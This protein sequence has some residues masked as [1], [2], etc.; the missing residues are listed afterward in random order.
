MGR[1]I[2][3]TMKSVRTL[4]ALALAAWPVAAGAS[5]GRIEL[6]QACATTGGCVPGD[7]AG[8]PLSLSAGGSYV[9]TSNLTV[10]DANTSGIEITANDVTIDFNGFTLAGP[11]TVPIATHVCTLPGAGSGVVK[12]APASGS[13]LTL[14]NGHIRGMGAYGVAVDAALARID[15]MVIERNCASGLL[16]GLGA[17]V[18]DTQVRA[19][20]SIGIEVGSGSRITECVVDNNG[21]DGIKGGGSAIVTGS[22]ITT[23]VGSGI[24]NAAVATGNSVVGNGIAGIGARLALQNYVEGNVSLGISAFGSGLNV[25]DSSGNGTISANRRV[26]CDYDGESLTTICPS[27]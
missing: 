24:A 19:N 20:A 15:G 12:P 5:D 17:I 10:P 2:E 23:N 8:F 11:A 14:K 18:T 4:A 13:G 6:N 7:A 9:L 1:G 26:A 3:S 25:S 16:L 21:G 27:P 22:L